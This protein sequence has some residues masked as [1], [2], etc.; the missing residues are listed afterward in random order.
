M[1]SRRAR[2]GFVLL[3]GLILPRAEATEAL[4]VAPGATMVFEFPELPPTLATQTGGLREAPRMTVKLPNNYRAEC[5]LP[6]FI[7]LEGNDGGRGDLREVNDSIVGRDDYVQ[8][9]LPLFK[10]EVKADAP[11]GGKLIGAA[12]EA[13]LKKAWGT[14]LQRLFTAVPNLTPKRSA[15]GGFSNGAHALS[16]LIAHPDPFLLAHFEEFFF[17]EGGFDSLT[18]EVMRGHPELAGHRFASFFSDQPPGAR[19]TELRRQGEAIQNAAR[20]RGLDFTAVTMPG[21]VHG[22]PPEYLPKLGDWVRG[23]KW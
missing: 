7:L 14:M 17:F 9:A 6:V 4:T 16:V 3:A 1:I 20:A 11:Y 13:V 2:L 5:R 15:I 18:P 22:L 23:G 8:V 10:T 21:A 12:D 19:R